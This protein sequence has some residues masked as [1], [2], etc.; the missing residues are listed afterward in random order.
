MKIL[1][2][3]D[4]NTFGYDPR[5]F[6]GSRY[7]KEHRW[8][9]VLADLSGWNMIN[10]GMNGR[11]IPL[12][13]PRLAADVDMIV[14]ML[15]TNDL[16]QGRSLNEIVNR[17]ECFLDGLQ[18]EDERIVLVAPPPM[19]LGEWVASNELVCHSIALG[20][21]YQSIAERRSVVFVDTAQ[22]GIEMSFDGIHFTEKGHQVFAECIYNFLLNKNRVIEKVL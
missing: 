21:E 15:G 11:G 12:K 10:E 7:S 18:I 14:I 4:S 6:L 19:Q 2:Y 20:A 13:G 9:D 5:S 1:C 8:V 16:L 3:G 17:M 22:W